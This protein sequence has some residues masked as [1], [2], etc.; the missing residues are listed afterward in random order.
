MGSPCSGTT[1]R[2]FHPDDGT[3]PMGASA[4]RRTLSVTAATTPALAAGASGWGFDPRPPAGARVADQSSSLAVCDGR[5]YL[6]R[7]Q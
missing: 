2:R 7:V 5:S 6:E 4:E 1:S 3:R